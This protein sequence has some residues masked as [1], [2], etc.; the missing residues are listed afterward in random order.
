L[1]WHIQATVSIKQ[2][3]VEQEARRKA[4]FIVATNVFDSAI[5]SDQKLA[6]T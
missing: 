3:Q 1:Q 6:T 4:C 5:L 2:P